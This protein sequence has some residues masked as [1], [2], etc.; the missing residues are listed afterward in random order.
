MAKE[1]YWGEIY[2]KLRYRELNCANTDQELIIM[3]TDKYIQQLYNFGKEVK[4]KFLN[5]PGV[6]K[7]IYKFKEEMILNIQ[8]MNQNMNSIQIFE[9]N[10]KECISAIADVNI[11]LLS[12]LNCCNYLL[13]YHIFSIY[14]GIL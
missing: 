10:T 6:I 5:N 7:Y 13:L 11:G 1:N 8:Q 9:A 14:S 3:E 2:W 12:S 4:E